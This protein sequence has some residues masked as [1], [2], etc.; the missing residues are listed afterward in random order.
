MYFSNS[1]VKTL[2]EVMWLHA[3][4]SSAELHCKNKLVVLTTE[5]L[6]WLQASCGYESF[7]LVTG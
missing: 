2:V 5:W 4:T 6:P 1:K 3:S 7:T